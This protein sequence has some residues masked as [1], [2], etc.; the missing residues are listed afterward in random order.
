MHD[1]YQLAGAIEAQ[2]GG[3]A[4]YVAIEAVYERHNGEPV[5]QGHVHVFDLNGHPT[6][7]RAY[8]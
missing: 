5:W 6:A 1:A 8:A 4:T 2:H 7:T 3:R